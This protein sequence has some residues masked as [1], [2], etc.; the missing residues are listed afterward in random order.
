MRYLFGLLIGVVL[1]GGIWFFLRPVPTAAP[2]QSSAP[3]SN[4]P[5]KTLGVDEKPT[6]DTP[7]TPAVTTVSLSGKNF[8][9]SQKEI[10]VKR[11]ARV[12]VNFTS[13]N[14]FHDW[15]IDAFNLRTKKLN[16]GEADVIEF[17]ADKAGTFDYYCSV[18]N[19]R[20]MGM[21]GKLIVE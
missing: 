7:I 14:G 5:E 21:V 8:S 17:T 10:R 20:Q 13:E 15:V 1:I 12:L 11:G 2:T 18:G 16:T 3:T 9:F 4:T 19:H 6:L